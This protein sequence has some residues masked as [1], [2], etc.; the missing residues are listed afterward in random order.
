MGGSHMLLAQ[1]AGQELW[2]EVSAVVKGGDYGW[3]V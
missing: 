1:D 3:I 2:E